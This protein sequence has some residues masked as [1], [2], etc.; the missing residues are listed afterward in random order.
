MQNI[1]VWMAK[2]FKY[3][4]VVS[5][6]FSFLSW[7]TEMMKFK[8][9]AVMDMEVIQTYTRIVLATNGK[10]RSSLQV[11]SLTFVIQGG[12]DVIVQNS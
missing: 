9:N 1:F 5:G 8:K 6:F 4:F 11:M 10:I 12:H 2:L 7:F 3:F